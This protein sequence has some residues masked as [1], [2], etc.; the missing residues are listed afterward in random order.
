[1]SRISSS[2][3]GLLPREITSTSKPTASY[4]PR[5]LDP[6]KHSG[7]TFRIPDSFDNISDERRRYL[8]PV[9]PCCMDQSV[10]AVIAGAI[11]LMRYARRRTRGRRP[12]WRLLSMS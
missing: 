10:D 9:A 11:G 7:V 5:I 12:R 4:P 6:L 8:A 1:M 3:T 2:R